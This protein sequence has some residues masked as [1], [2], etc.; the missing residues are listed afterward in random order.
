MTET[1]SKTNSLG[2]FQNNKSE[3]YNHQ[4]K[5]KLQPGPNLKWQGSV[6]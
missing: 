2:C 1:N 6:W 3:V 4:K 5:S